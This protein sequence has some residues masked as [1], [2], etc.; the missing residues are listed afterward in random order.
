MDAAPYTGER[1]VE[2]LRQ[3]ARTAK[4]EREVLRRVREIARRAAQGKA[5]WLKPEMCQPDPD[6][7]FGVYVLHE[8][9]DHTLAV[10]VASWL[11]QRGT[12][13]HDHGTWAVVV[14][15]DGDE[16]NE[17]WE[18]LDDRSRPGY[19]ELRKIGEKVFADGDVLVMPAGK[20]HSVHNDTDRVTLSLHIYGR[21]VNHT[22]R[23]QFDPARR[24]ETPYKV[25][26]RS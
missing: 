23:S 25:V 5:S 19:A 14:G 15:I 18:R 2:D 12:T 6:Q 22:E 1:L 21:H 3:A 13:P 20:I 10:F 9:A 17:F 24:T 8:E 11:P 7:G 26:T 4:D 16:R